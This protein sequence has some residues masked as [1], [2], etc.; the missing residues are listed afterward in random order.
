MIGVITNTVTVIIGSLI[1]MPFNKGIP[2][3]F[4]D[5]LMKTI[6]LCTIYIG[7]SGALEGKKTLVLIVSMVLGVLIGELLKLDDLLNKIA[8]K[9]ENKLSKSSDI[10]GKISTGFISATML[11]CVGSMTIVGSLN[12]GLLGD[13]NLLFTKALLDFISSIVLASTFGI[14]VLIS[15]VS[16]LVL[17]GAIVLLAR[18]ISPIL[19]TVIIAEMTCVGSIIILALGLN[20][21]GLTKFKIA[22]FLPAVFLPIAIYPLYNLIEKLL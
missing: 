19:S 3:K 4:S 22:N 1:G 2:K 15:S 21:I 17:Q 20:L 9:L 7:I 14:G 13:N 18:L 8:E 6:G 11:F 16:V 5:V 10:K 12:A